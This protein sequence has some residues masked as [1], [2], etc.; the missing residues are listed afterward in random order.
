MLSTPIKLYAGLGIVAMAALAAAFFL[1]G[2]VAAFNDT[3]FPAHR[4]VANRVVP[5]IIRTKGLRPAYDH[6]VAA[7]ARLHGL[8]HI[9]MTNVS[10]IWVHA[11]TDDWILL[12]GPRGTGTC[13]DVLAAFGAVNAPVD[14]MSLSAVR[15]LA[16]GYNGG[17]V[18]LSVLV[19]RFK[20]PPAGLSR[21]AGIAYDQKTGQLRVG[22]KF[23]AYLAPAQPQLVTTSR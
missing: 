22:S 16:S 6:Q 10:D 21:C 14:A 4:A 18:Q 15:M 12:N 7:S 2:T 1:Q 11:E 3:Y 20:S 5:E 19:P 23:I 8:Q 17:P 9:A 13:P